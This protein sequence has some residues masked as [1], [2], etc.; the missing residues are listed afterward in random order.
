MSVAHI[1]VIVRE[2]GRIVRLSGRWTLATT[3]LRA[4]ALS[5]RAGQV[6]D[7]A[8]SWDCLQ[9]EAIDSAGAM[10][11]WRAWGRA[12]PPQLSI[13]PEHWRVFERIDVADHEPREAVVAALAPAR[14]DRGRFG[15]DR[16]RS[17]SRRFRRTDRPVRI[18]NL[19][20][21]LRNPADLPRGRFRPTFTRAEC[22]RCRSRRW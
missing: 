16:H 5:A 21:V 8:T 12:M 10:L 4:A 14:R 7:P 22:A 18:L 13:K 19:V 20:H 3:S 11:L 17:A 1:E 15:D 2:G 6:A 9:L